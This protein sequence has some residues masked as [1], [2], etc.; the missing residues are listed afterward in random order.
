MLMRDLIE[1]RIL[2]CTQWRNFDVHKNCVTPCLRAPSRESSLHEQVDQRW[3]VI[4]FICI[5][6]RSRANS[7]ASFM[8][9]LA[10]AKAPS[11]SWRV[12]VQEAHLGKIP[13]CF[14]LCNSVKHRNQDQVR[15]YLPL[16]MHTGCSRSYFVAYLYY[17]IAHIEVVPGTFCLSFLLMLEMAD[18]QGNQKESHF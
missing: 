18:D 15:S 16:L 3:S 7:I 2:M 1:Q 6:L 8:A 17:V 14:F 4:I 10:P 12:Q 13:S 5:L 11:N 9:L